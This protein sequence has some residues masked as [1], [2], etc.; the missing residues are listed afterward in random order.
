VMSRR[1]SAG[2]GGGGTL[3][4]SWVRVGVEQGS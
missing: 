2:E 3:E 4:S 1:R